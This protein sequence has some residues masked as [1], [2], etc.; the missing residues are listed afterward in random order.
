MVNYNE[1]REEMSSALNS[2]VLLVHARL[3]FIAEAVSEDLGYHQNCNFTNLRID[4]NVKKMNKKS[5]D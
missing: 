5:T 1:D 2:T 4:E 3:Y